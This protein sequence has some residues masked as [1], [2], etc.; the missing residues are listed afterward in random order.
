LIAESPEWAMLQEK[1]IGRYGRVWSGKE[2]A[3]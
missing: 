3:I 1:L 2:A